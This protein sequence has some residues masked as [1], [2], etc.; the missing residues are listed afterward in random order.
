MPMGKLATGKL[1]H[2]FL[3][4]LLRNYTSADERVLLGSR[5][6]E[7]ATIIDMGDRVLIAKTDPIT[8][9]TDQIGYYAVH[10]NANDI[11]CMGG[12]PRWFLV[13]ILLPE[14]CDRSL[15][16]EIFRQI[17]RECGRERISLCGGHTEVTLGL[18]RPIVV[19]QMLGE[20]AKD[21]V[22]LKSN[23]RPGD[24]IIMVKAIP[25]EGTSIIAREKAADLQ[26]AYSEDFVRRCQNFLFDPGLSVR[27]TAELAR[28]NV[29][30]RAM[31]DPTEGG[32]TTALHELAAAA[33][34]K[35]RID[36]SRILI[37]PEGKLLCDRY[38]LDPLGCIASGSLLVV[39]PA[40]AVATLL[41]VYR[42][43]DIPAADIGVLVDDAERNILITEHGA[44]ELPIFSQDEIVKIF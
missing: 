20:A 32:L 22:V 7:D 30:V 34:L 12:T 41:A 17:A 14:A 11:A 21:D 40:S 16:E 1:D 39:V 31:H 28:K 18:D 13:T 9:V 3:D 37:S 43:H 10:V 42:K 44:E 27:R 33:N 15:A 4:D 6:G 5:L 8:F 29:P 36:A 25:I 38:R 23:A 19:G 24:H 35:A 2:D 26:A